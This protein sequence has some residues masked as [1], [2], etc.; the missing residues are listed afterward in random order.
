MQKKAL[1]FAL[2][3]LCP[4]SL[5][6]KNIPVSVELVEIKAK[7]L[8]EKGGDEVY[9]T[10]TQYS[11]V[12]GSAQTRIPMFPTHW[13]SK[14]LSQ[15]KKVSL[16][17]GEVG[18]Q[19]SIQLVLTLIEHDVPPWNVDD[20]LGSVKLNLMQEQGRLKSKWGIPNYQD[21]TKISTG[22]NLTYDF[23]GP[24]GEYQVTFKL[25]VN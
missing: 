20:H 21:Q 23:Q 11:S 25:S 7:A 13:L 12:R 9:F 6:A 15:L 10:V 8:G 16:W 3:L 4:M 14:H 1:L 5:F 17:Q 2:V 18:E 19:E 24:D 22:D